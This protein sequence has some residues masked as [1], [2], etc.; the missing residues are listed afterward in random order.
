MD[1]LDDVGVEGIAAGGED[2]AVVGVW[3]DAMCFV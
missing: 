1:E 3:D 2:G